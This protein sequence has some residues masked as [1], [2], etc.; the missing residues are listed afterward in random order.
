MVNCNPTYSPP[1]RG[2]MYG[3][4]ARFEQGD[5]EFDAGIQYPFGGQFSYAPMDWY[6]LEAGVSFASGI[7]GYAGPRFS[8]WPVTKQDHNVKLLAE[9]EMGFGLGAGGEYCGNAPNSSLGCDGPGNSTWELDDPQKAQK[10]SWKRFAYGG[11]GGLGLGLGIYDWVD[12]FVKAR[13]QE[14]K[15]K[16]IPPTLWTSAGLGIQVNIHKSLKLYVYPLQ[17]Y[18]YWNRLDGESEY[19]LEFGLGF[20]HNLLKLSSSPM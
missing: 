12:L 8:L 9:V 3:S 20:N 10:S 18:R 7:M 1:V 17:K 14:T 13:I 6:L 2:L 15:A 16:G 4:P 19:I 5:L 11:Y